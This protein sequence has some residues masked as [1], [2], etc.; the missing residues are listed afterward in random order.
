MT[1][2]GDACTIIL[3][4][5]RPRYLTRRSLGEGER[6]TLHGVLS[7]PFNPRPVAAFT[8]F[9]LHLELRE[10]PFVFMKVTDLDEGRPDLEGGVDLADN[11]IHDTGDVLLK[12]IRFEPVK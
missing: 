1:D 3:C 11:V 4:P 12:E 2:K 5:P 10:F 7:L 9:V 8:L 6:G